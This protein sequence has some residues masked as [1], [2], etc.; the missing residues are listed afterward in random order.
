MEFINWQQVRNREILKGSWN[1]CTTP[2]GIPPLIIKLVACDQ[3]QNFVISVEW[4]VP[5][6]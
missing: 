4:H 6:P 2:L 1:H 3:K 5:I